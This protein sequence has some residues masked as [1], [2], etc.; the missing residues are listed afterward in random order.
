M[1]G[2][3]APIADLARIARRHG[4]LTIVD[5]A[6]GIGTVGP[7]GRGVTEGLP[8]E[9]RP[10]ILLG[11]ASKALGVEGGFVCVCETLATLIRNCARGYVFSSAPSPAVVAAVAASVHQLRTDVSPVQ[12]LQTTVARARRA[13]FEAGLIPAPAANDLG[14]IIRVPV[15]PEDRAVVAQEELGR[16]G[17]MIG[18]IRYPAVPRGEAILRVCLTA[19]HTDAHIDALV[20]SLRDVLNTV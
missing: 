9:L 5:D 20:D 2:D 6:H 4:A 10:D 11:T 13:L 17:L 14:P 1:G 7:T 19:A 12:R 18:A 16:R 8:Q 15:G 3:V